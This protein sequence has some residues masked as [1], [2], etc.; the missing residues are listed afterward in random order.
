MEI[1]KGLEKHFLQT[2]L[3]TGLKA[4]TTAPGT[5]FEPQGTL[6]HVVHMPFPGVICQFKLGP[7]GLQY[8]RGP[9]HA[10]IQLPELIALFEAVNPK[11]AEPPNKGPAQK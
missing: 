7:G 6:S 1:P 9:H 4:G 8:H 3:I 10:V 2:T 11:F 5:H